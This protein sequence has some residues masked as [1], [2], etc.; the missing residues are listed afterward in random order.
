MSILLIGCDFL[1]PKGDLEFGPI[2][3]N[4]SGKSSKVDF[5]EVSKRV[6]IPHCIKCHENYMSYSTVYSNRKQ[7]L[8]SVK[9]NRMPKKASAL[10]TEL[11]ELIEDWI[12]GGAIRTNSD[13]GSGR[14]VKAPLGLSSKLKKLYKVH[15]K[16]HPVLDKE[17]DLTPSR[18]GKKFEYNFSEGRVAQLQFGV[19]NNYKFIS[20]I[21][22]TEN[23]CGD[24]KPRV[25]LYVA[26]GKSFVK[27]LGWVKHPQA[28]KVNQTLEVREKS[29]NGEDDEEQGYDAVIDENLLSANIG[30]ISPQLE[31]GVKDYIICDDWNWVK[32]NKIK[33]L[34][35]GIERMESNEE[36]QM[37]E[38]R[39]IGGAYSFEMKKFDSEIYT[40]SR[41]KYLETNF[42][43]SS[44]T[45]VIGEAGSFHYE[46]N[47]KQ[48]MVGF[49]FDLNSLIASYRE[50]QVPPEELVYSPYHEGQ[51]NTFNFNGNDF[52]N[53]LMNTAIGV[54]GEVR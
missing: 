35:W 13:L 14:V 25:C 43:R 6:L 46:M 16:K 5:N 33:V 42:G 23:T 27:R 20:R 36:T 1:G 50:Q 26:H 32:G 47:N 28:K 7:I 12:D 54:N 8:R 17:N 39:I 45:T 40:L 10:K 41:P 22:F 4:R 52:F 31:S 24:F 30:T 38:N 19:S 53:N 44:F 18:K 34:S 51:D 29:E 2:A 49:K 48:C 15:S 9:S 11:K 3:A 21:D 37:S